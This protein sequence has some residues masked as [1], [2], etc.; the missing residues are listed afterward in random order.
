MMGPRRR[1][2]TGRRDA[3]E[4]EIIAALE[5]VGARVRKL[6]QPVDLLVAFNGYVF[7]IEVKPPA[8]SAQ[9]KAHKAD[10]KKRERAERQR[11]WLEQWPGPTAVVETAE[12]AL[13]L[14]QKYRVGS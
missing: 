6:D 9:G 8:D 13:E 5:A 10:R 14:I 4:P 7:L 11:Q 3:N 1:N 12:Q 2:S